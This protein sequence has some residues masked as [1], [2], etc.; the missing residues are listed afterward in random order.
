M[1]SINV[2]DCDYNSD[3]IKKNIKY[4]LINERPSS[5]DIYGDGRSGE[6]IAKILKDV[7]LINNK[8]IFY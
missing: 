6:R 4:W 7:K 5:S 1:R 3:E 8:T 2:R